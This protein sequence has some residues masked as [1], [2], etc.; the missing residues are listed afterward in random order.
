M[1]RLK[2]PKL[3]IANELFENCIRHKNM[4]EESLKQWINDS[5]D[6]ADD[7][8]SNDRGDTVCLWFTEAFPGI[9]SLPYSL[10]NMTNVWR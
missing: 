7:N 4:A 2:L 10:T 1:R 5:S 3:Y 9:G 8:V 6:D